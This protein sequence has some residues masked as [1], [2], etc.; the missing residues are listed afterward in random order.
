MGEARRVPIDLLT[1]DETNMDRLDM[2]V[3]GERSNIARNTMNAR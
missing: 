2:V 1:W 3:T